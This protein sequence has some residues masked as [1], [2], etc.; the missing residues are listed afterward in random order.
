MSAPD[1]ATTDLHDVPPLAARGRWTVLDIALLIGVLALALVLRL[2]NYDAEFSLDELW[3]LATTPG[4]G[5]LLGQF[6]TDVLLNGLPSQTSLENAAPV[7]RIWT[8]MDGVLHPPLFIILLRVWREIFGQSDFAAHFYSTFWSMISIGFLFAIARLAMDR[9][10]A[11]L[12]CLGTAVS[13][14]Q[15]YFAQEVRA[16]QMIIAIS[17]I[18]LWVMT[19]IEV[20]GSTRRRAIMLAALTFPLLLTHYFTAGGA[21]AVGIYGVWRLRGHR[22]SF[23]VT[24]AAA[25]LL[26]VVS[27]V[28]FAL[29]Q[30]NDLYTGDA[31]LTDEHF[32]VITELARMC[33]APWRTLNDVDYQ[34]DAATLL[35]GLLFVAPWFLIRRNRALLPW[36][37][38]LS[39]VI[40]AIAMLDV[41]RSTKHLTFPRYFAAASPTV[42]LL[43]V[44]AA[45]ALD[46]KLAYIV[47]GGLVL[48][49]G[50]GGRA[51]QRMSVD[52]PYHSDARNYVRDRIAP[53]EALLIYNGLAPKVYDDMLALAFSHSPTF[54]SRPTVLMTRPLSSEIIQQ[55]PRRAWLVMGGVDMN[56]LDA[57][58]NFTVLEQKIIE[59]QGYILHVQLRGSE[60]AATAPASRPVE[61]S[62]E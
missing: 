16:Y 27:W 22:V 29:Q 5:N 51:E 40:L 28:P 23:L 39:G 36:A 47:G 32:S 45:W 9:W 37:M 26:Y 43:A 6:P 58:A 49:V 62:H 56:R 30:V 10:A 24:C 4:L 2:M 55:L 12:V 33:C 41:V 25:G 31:F 17:T 11:L 18:I 59:D 57:L 60:N 19:R 1:A 42:L 14:A 13:Q 34:A 46:R 3:H 50:I 7:W 48:L 54:A 52:S 21:L 38:W 35:A 53:D 61:T 44:G 15:I 20:V 8:G